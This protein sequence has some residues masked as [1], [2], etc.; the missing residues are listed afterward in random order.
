MHVQN[1]FFL[2][3][4]VLKKFRNSNSG[5]FC[6]PT[7]ITTIGSLNVSSPILCHLPFMPWPLTIFLRFALFVTHPQAP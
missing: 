2:P 7:S 1:G 4:F 6:H 3:K 5:R